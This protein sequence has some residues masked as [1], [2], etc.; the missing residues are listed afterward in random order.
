MNNCGN[1]GAETPLLESTYTFSNLHVGP[2]ARLEI[3]SA[4]SVTLEPSTLTVQ[5]DG[6]IV[7]EGQLTSS[8]GADFTLVEIVSGGRLRVF[9]PGQLDWRY[10]R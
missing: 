2:G 7:L 9:G 4:V 6:E 8:G 1:A 3:P 5:D 10:R